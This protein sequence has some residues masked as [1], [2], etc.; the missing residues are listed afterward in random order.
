MTMELR[1]SQSQIRSLAARYDAEQSDKDRSLTKV[2][3][4]DVFPSYRKKGFLTK[5]EFLD[6][7]AWKTPRSQPRCA[8]NDATFIKELSA[9]VLTTASEQ[10]RIQA[11]ILL[12]GV[13]W[14]TASVFLHFAFPNKY[15]IMDFRAL[16]S[17]KTD[18]PGQ[19]TFSFWQEYT[20]FCRA[21]ARQAGVTM[22]ILDQAL[23]KYSET[24]QRK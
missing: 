17:L 3:A 22:R 2:I 13:K 11:W 20:A 10:L 18:V 5:K 24:N 7:C 12:A 16:W 4:Q 19:Y 23:W 6:V 1:F 15:P 21:L 14:P 8:S 9:L